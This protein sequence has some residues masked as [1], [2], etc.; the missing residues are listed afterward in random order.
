[1]RRIITLGLIGSLCLPV[2]AHEKPYEHQHV[3]RKDGMAFVDVPKTQFQ[4]DQEKAKNI[5]LWGSI[6][7]LGGL[8]LMAVSFETSCPSGLGHS[9]LGYDCYAGIDKEISGIRS[10]LFSSGESP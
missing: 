9:Y 10:P 1:M 8:V 5:R 3:Q 6:T 2:F 4:R 7:M